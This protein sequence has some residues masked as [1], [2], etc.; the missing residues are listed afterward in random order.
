MVSQYLSRVLFTQLLSSTYQPY[1]TI[2][3]A[4]R[5]DLPCFA[6]LI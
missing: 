4:S 6:S 3:K 1:L 5:G 2:A